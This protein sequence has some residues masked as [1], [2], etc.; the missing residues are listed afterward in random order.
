MQL[1]RNLMGTGLAEFFI[2]E[3]T[4]SLI[5]SMFLEFRNFRLLHPSIAWCTKDVKED[6]GPESIKRDDLSCNFKTPSKYKE[7]VVKLEVRALQ[8][9][10]TIT[11][12]IVRC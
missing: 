3:M 6:Y 10:T 11:Q 2:N 5:F 9:S 12:I 7:N 8:Q 1:L 4:K